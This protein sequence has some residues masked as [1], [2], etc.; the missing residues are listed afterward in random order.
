MGWIDANLNK[1]DDLQKQAEARLAS[2]LTCPV[3][4]IASIAGHCCAAGSMLA[5]ACDYR[6]MGEKGLFF[7]PAVELGL[8]YSPGMIS[9]MQSKLSPNAQRDIILFGH[10]YNSKSLDEQL[11][12]S[13]QAFRQ[14]GPAT[15]TASH[16]PD[17]SSNKFNPNSESDYVLATSMEFL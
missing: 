6:V 4:T 8:V 10:R 9:L 17:I 12:L 16:W 15:T 3:P 7:I 11:N 14:R 5:L 2:L 13:R 1:A